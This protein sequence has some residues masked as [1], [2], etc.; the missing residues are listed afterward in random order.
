MSENSES[1]V[2]GIN[3]SK[4]ISFTDFT[5]L[6]PLIMPIFLMTSDRPEAA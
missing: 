1:S 5:Q 2:V 4:A 3:V 6:S